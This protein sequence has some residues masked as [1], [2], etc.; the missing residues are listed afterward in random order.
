MADLSVIVI[1]YNEESNIER[2]LRSLSF[3]DELIIIDSFSTDS[4]TEKARQFTDKIIKHE[5]DGDIHQRVRGFSAAK[6][7][8]LMYVDADEEISDELK[9]EI[10]KVIVSKDSADG[11][12]VVRKVFSFGK[13]IMHGGWFPDRSFRLFKKDKYIP[14]YAEV[15]GGFTTKGHIGVLNGFLYHYS[16]PTIGDYLRKMNDYTSLQVS[17]K[18]KTDKVES[19]GIMKILFS[20][21]SHFF[22]RYFS[23]K[24]YK[25]GR[26]GFVLAVLSAISTLALYSKLWE[27]LHKKRNNLPL[28]PITNAEVRRFREHYYPT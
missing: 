2:C 16:Y 4:T 28:P 3:A 1:T 25:D 21:I 24:G 5:Y 15:H 23:Q 26:V 6:N 27:C 17:N 22:R 9:D 14:E 19:V 13:W 10:Q 11:Y 20:P 18:L 8:W 7:E 12:Y